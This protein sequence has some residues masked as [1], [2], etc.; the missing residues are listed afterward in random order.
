[1]SDEKNISL[2]HNTG[3]EALREYGERL[4][5]LLV[6][7]MSLSAD[8]RELGAEIAAAGFNYRALKKVVKAR[9]SESDGKTKPMETLREE[10]GDLPVYLDVLAPEQ[11]AE[12]AE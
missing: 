5:R 3:P 11:Q 12:A 10:S 7:H 6:E 4:H 1:M 8:I 9:I 2:G